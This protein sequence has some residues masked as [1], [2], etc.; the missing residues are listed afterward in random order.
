MQQSYADAIALV[1]VTGANQLTWQT[2]PAS[3]WRGADFKSYGI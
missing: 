1:L 2:F 3:L